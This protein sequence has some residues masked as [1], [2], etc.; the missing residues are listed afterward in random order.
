MERIL[1]TILITGCLLAFQGCRCDSGMEGKTSPAA[2]A[3]KDRV[4][5]NAPMR[6]CRACALGKAFTACKRVDGQED[7]E[8]LTRKAEL[9]ACKDVGL[10]EEQCTGGVLSHIQCGLMP[11]SQ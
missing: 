6:W 2:E 3:A 4:T 7:E 9:A 8:T 5:S 1:Q 11:P 10:G